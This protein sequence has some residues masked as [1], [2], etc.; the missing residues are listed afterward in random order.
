MKKG[1]HEKDFP[2]LGVTAHSHGSFSSQRIRST[3]S[4]VQSTKSRRIPSL[5]L[6]HSRIL[7]A[8][9]ESIARRRE[10][11]IAETSL[12]SPSKESPWLEKKSRSAETVERKR[13]AAGPRKAW[14]LRS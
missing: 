13:S 1:N 7:L 14:F 3:S 10:V 12:T 11:S 4:L 6:S 2:F 9:R 8:A 5:E